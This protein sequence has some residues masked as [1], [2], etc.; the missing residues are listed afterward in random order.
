MLLLLL[1]VC[2]GEVHDTYL[3]PD[4]LAEKS[5]LWPVRF[6]ITRDEGANTSC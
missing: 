2:D 3:E 4:F 6:V 1:C 5:S